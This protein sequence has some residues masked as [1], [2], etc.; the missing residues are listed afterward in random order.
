MPDWNLVEAREHLTDDFSWSLKRTK[1]L[2]VELCNNDKL[3]AESADHGIPKDI[4]GT[5]QI[6]DNIPDNCGQEVR[7]WLNNDA[8]D[9]LSSFRYSF[10]I[11]R[12]EIRFAIQSNLVLEFVEMLFGPIQFD[13]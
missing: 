2:Y 1:K 5:S 9:W 4:Q 8:D 10:C 7:K 6:V 13:T 12:V 3:A 11:D